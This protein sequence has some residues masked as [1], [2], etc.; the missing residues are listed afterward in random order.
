M[1]KM[2]FYNLSADHQTI[3][4]EKDILVINVQV[5]VKRRSLS[6]FHGLRLLSLSCSGRTPYMLTSGLWLFL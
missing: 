2:I 5:R 4:G 6:S 1:F 3:N